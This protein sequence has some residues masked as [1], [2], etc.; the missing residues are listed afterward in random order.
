MRAKHLDVGSPTLHATIFFTIAVFTAIITMAIVFKVEV[1]ATGLGKVVPTSRVQVIQ[2]EFNGQITA[3]HVR[4]GDQVLA[5]DLLIELNQ[6]DAVAELETVQ[7]ETD[8]LRIEEARLGRMLELVDMPAPNPEGLTF[9]APDLLEAHPYYRQQMRLLL[10]EYEDYRASIDQIRSRI[11][12]N[13]RSMAVSMAAVTRIEDALQTR[14]ERMQATQQLMEQGTTPRSAW[15]EMLESFQNLENERE[16]ALRELDTKRSQETSLRAEQRAVSANLRNRLLQRLNEIDARQA[17]LGAQFAV[18]E[19]RV[20][21]ARLL[22][23]VSG[24]V[25]QLDVFTIG[26]VVQ[27]GQELLRIVPEEAS[28]EIEAMFANLDVGFLKVGQKAN[29]RLD[30]FPSERFG[31]AT[32]RVIDISADSVEIEDANFVYI[33]RASPDE[34]VLRVGGTEHALKPGMTLTVDVITDERR[35]ISYFFAP[36]MEV[37]ERSLGER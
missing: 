31:F 25:D 6:T 26:G 27:A 28:V 22:A 33:V 10:A 23:P 37:I 17:S 24:V 11:E 15:L 18:L 4:N 12:T 30:A 16:I 9:S 20:A 19:R 13:E 8:R 21:A 5:G 29:I 7:S 14:G 35:I 32:G 1:V 34:P 36:I 3:I 2:P